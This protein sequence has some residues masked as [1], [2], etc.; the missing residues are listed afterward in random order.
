MKKY[1]TYAD[2]LLIK[3]FFE[4]PAVKAAFIDEKEKEIYNRCDIQEDG[5]ITFG[6]TSCKWW[7]R[8]I[9]CEKIISFNEFAM[10]IADVISG[11][12][13]NKNSKILNGLLEIIARKGITNEDYTYV[14]DQL[15]VAIKFGADGP[16]KSKVIDLSDGNPIHKN[17]K[18]L[19]YEIS[20]GHG[21]FQLNPFESLGLKIKAKIVGIDADN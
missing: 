9:G 17:N 15:L 3:Y 18:H 14:I 4:D 11:Q 13:N 2:T 7:N 16:L 12:K 10:K 20:D 1:L 6:K 21:Y 8:I 5:S 19:E